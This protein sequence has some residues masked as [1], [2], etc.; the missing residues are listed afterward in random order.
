VRSLLHSLS[1]LE[2]EES[3]T[4]NEKMQFVHMI[5]QNIYRSKTLLEFLNTFVIKGINIYYGYHDK[6]YV[7]N[8][9][10]IVGV[11]GVYVEGYVEDSQG[12]VNK[13]V[14]L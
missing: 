3:K 5:I 9:Q 10:L 1:F 12:Q 6:V 7:I 8:K 11:F 4:Y 2:C 13:I 14:P